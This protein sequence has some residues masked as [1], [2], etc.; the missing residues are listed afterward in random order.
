QVDL[1]EVADDDLDDLLRTVQNLAD[2][3]AEWFPRARTRA[4]L[5]GT[6]EG[7]A[8]VVPTGQASAFRERLRAL[9]SVPTLTIDPNGRTV[10]LEGRSVSLT[11]TELALL[12]HL[13][14]A[15][16]RVVTRAALLTSVW[17]GRDVPEGSRTIDV[18]VR[19]LRE[20]TGLADLVVTARGTGYRIAPRYDVRILG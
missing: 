3:A 8:R 19:R 14:Q 15:S 18:H 1:S 17:G 5:T 7:S 10:T 12:V 9:P 6:T 2:L 16:P 4:A 13:A 11:V 20:K